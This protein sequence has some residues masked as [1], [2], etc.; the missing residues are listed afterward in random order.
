MKRNWFSS[1]SAC[2]LAFLTL[3]TIAAIAQESLPFPSPPSASIA[4]P[5]MQ[6]SVH[7]WRSAP[8]RL[9]ADAPNILIIL[10]DDTGP[11]LPSTYGGE[12]HTP[13]LD[14]VAKMGISYNSFHSTAMCSPTR[15]ALLTG[16]NHTRVGNGQIA[17]LA[18]DWDGFTGY[19]PRSSATVAEVLRDYGYNTS[20]FRKM[21]HDR[22]Q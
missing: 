14:R 15:A 21:A 18:N 2:G 17:E 3:S 9:P 11:G 22:R 1:A 7:K 5:T 8:S 16:R 20:A 19:I 6:D 4:G 10:L 13:T 12:I